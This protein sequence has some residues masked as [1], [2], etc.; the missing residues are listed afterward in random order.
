VLNLEE[1]S[2]FNATVE[3]FV[4]LAEADRWGPRDPRSVLS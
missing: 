4:A 2:L 3:R 1:P